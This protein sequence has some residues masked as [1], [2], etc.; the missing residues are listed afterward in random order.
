[1]TERGIAQ[2]FASRELDGR[3]QVVT[4]MNLGDELP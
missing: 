4:R 3:F 2:S 1:M